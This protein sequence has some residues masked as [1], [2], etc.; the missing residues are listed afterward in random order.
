M[1][2]HCKAVH[3][4]VSY[5]IVNSMVKVARSIMRCCSEPESQWEIERGRE[6]VILTENVVAVTEG[7][8]EH[9]MELSKYF[10]YSRP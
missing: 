4:L 5:V 9:V 3:I 6:R 1:D 8:C 2:L 7:A 10:I